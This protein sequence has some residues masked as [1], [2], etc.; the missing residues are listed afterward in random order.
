MQEQLPRSPYNKRLCINLLP[1]LT[2]W[3]AAKDGA[4][5]EKSAPSQKN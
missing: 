1:C 5:P 3:I 2:V 4:V